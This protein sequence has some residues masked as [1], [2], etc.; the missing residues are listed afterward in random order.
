MK[1]INIGYMLLMMLCFACTPDDYDVYEMGATDM[2][3]IGQI[4]LCL[5]HYQ[6]LAD[7]KAELELTPIGH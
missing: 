2:A 3:N 5:S 7:G 4:K 6:L 1:R